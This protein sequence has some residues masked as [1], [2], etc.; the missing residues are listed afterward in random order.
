MKFS[1]CPHRKLLSTFKVHFKFNFWLPHFS[2][3]S[4]SITFFHTPC[5]I[6]STHFF[7]AVAV[8]C[9]SSFLYDIKF[10]GRQG[11]DFFFF[12]PETGFYL[13][14]DAGCHRG[15]REMRHQTTWL[16]FQLYILFSELNKASLISS[17]NLLFHLF[18]KYL[19]WNLFKNII[20]TTIH[21]GSA[22]VYRLYEPG[23]L[24]SHRAQSWEGLCPWLHTVLSSWNS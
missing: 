6:L 16:P 1:L 3:V 5:R 19:F 17:I 11:M 22:L 12:F 10:H 2:H 15:W 8:R 14:W 9:H 13:S 24:F 23:T 7:W 18:N 4:L 20:E 21:F